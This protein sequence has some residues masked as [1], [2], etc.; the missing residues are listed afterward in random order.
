MTGQDGF[1]GRRQL[2]WWAFLGAALMATTAVE[3]D[4]HR[5]LTLSFGYDDLK[6]YRQAS[7]LFALDY[8]FGALDEAERWS[9]RLGA[10]VMTDGDVWAGVGLRY[11]RP[12]FKNGWFFDASFG[13]G[14]Y[15]RHD[16][17][18]GVSHFHLPMFRTE[19][20]IGRVLESGATLS[21]AL[22]HLSDA[23]LREPAGSTETLFVR[24][25]WRY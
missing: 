1:S 25:G 4:D 10:M 21:V 5:G 3:A 8:D 9:W 11:R 7:P 2:K 17:V 12:I 14:M 13:P 22:S 20:G 16:E 15:Y 23:G 24:Y 6:K 19:G 18:V